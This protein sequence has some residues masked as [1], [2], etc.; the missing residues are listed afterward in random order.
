MKKQ[1]EGIKILVVDDDILISNM[2]ELNL[3]LHGATVFRAGD[4]LAAMEIIK[5]NSVDLILSDMRMAKSSGVD[6]LKNLKSTYPQYPPLFFMTGFA[7]EHSREQLKQLGATEVISKPFEIQQLLDLIP[8][9]LK[10]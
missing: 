8:A 10:K 4:G 5:T 3:N 2:I 6:L 7:T 9:N 1:L